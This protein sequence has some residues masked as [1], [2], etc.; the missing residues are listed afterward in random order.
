M[1]KDTSEPSSNHLLWGIAG[2]ALGAIWTRS[3][4]EASKKSRAEIDAPEEA[5]EV[6]EEIAELLEA[7]EPSDD[8]ETEDDFTQDLANFLEQHSE[9]EIEVYA[10][11]PEGK[12]DIL[13]GDL[14]ALELKINPGKSERDRLIGQCAG[15]S[16]LWITWAVVIGSSESRIG[17]LVDL[18]EDKGLNQIAVWGF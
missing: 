18:L 2:L 4:L 8:C 9:W 16:R 12:P 11:S 10:D 17:R 15:Y 14:L 3:E 1:S 7:W 13:I 6:S 5:E